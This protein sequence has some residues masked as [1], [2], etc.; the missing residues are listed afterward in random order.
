MTTRADMA[1]TTPQG[2]TALIVEIATRRGADMAWIT[3]LR[4]NLLFHG[5]L[6]PTPYMLIVF[7]EQM[8]L[9]TPEQAE[10]FEAEPTYVVDTLEVFH[11][12]P[13]FAE[14]TLDM[15][16]GSMLEVITGAWLHVIINLEP[17]VLAEQSTL[18]WVLD[19]G[20]FE[21]IYHGVVEVETVS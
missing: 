18:H 11:A 3:R 8:C 6:P 17:D 12:V 16:R 14:V 2:I 19:S 21:Y 7:P 13:G 15:L 10:L 20:L 5:F 4:R 1:V 9:W